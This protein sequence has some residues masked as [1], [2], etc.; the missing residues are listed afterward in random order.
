MTDT[1]DRFKSLAH[2]L[3]DLDCRATGEHDGGVTVTDPIGTAR[4]VIARRTGH[5]RISPFGTAGVPI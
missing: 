4:V 1:P 5:T 2:E 3:T